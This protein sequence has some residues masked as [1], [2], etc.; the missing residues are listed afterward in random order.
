MLKSVCAH[1]HGLK[2]SSS[3]SQISFGHVIHNRMTPSTQTRHRISLPVVSTP[4][5]STVRDFL[6]ILLHS[7]QKKLLS[8]LTRLSTKISHPDRFAI[9]RHHY[10]SAFTKSSSLRD[11][12]IVIYQNEKARF[13]DTVLAMVSRV[14]CI[15]WQHASISRLHSVPIKESALFN[16]K[17]F[18][19]R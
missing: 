10:L 6:K 5:Y 11:E 19:G 4:E 13:L 7:T 16:N 8:L 9:S 12:V 15:Q 1:A 2:A 3:S 18:F 17:A 14:D